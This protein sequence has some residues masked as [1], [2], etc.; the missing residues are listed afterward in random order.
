MM[1][2]FAFLGGLI[3]NLMPCVFPVLSIKALALA[4]SGGES[5]AVQ[6]SHALAYTAG[7]VLSFLAVAGLL[8]VL[9]AG[10]ASLGWGFQLQSPVFV[11]VLIYVLFALGL[12][13]SGLVE[14]GGRLMGAGQSLAAKP[15]H[16]GAFFT[17]VLAVLVASPCTAPF[18]GAALGFALTQ[19]AW[20]SLTV[21][22]ALGLGL[23][24]PFL[25]I[26]FIPALARKLPR[27]GA[28]MVTFRQAMAFPLYLTVVWLL[29]VLARQTD[30]DAVGLVLVGLTGLAFGLWLKS[31]A[32]KYAPAV[33]IVVAL[34]A[35][36]HPALRAAPPAVAGAGI[37]AAAW[38]PYS[39]DRVQALAAGG[40]TV[41]VNFTAD[42]CLTCKVNERTTLASA[43]VQRA[44]AEHNIALV[45]GDWTRYDPAITAALAEHGRS[46]VPLYLVVR[47]D[48]EA[49][50]LPQILTPGGVIE[51]LK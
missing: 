23:A 44:F 40:Q 10:G 33:V 41:F 6:R 17:G 35:L 48:G 7:V 1:L 24:A 9:R 47:P 18:M 45:K 12:S 46:G 19:S 42:W 39:A 34:G 13:M 11:A 38:Q 37:D 22:A 14:F 43:R 28:W 3:L 25:A 26:G 20:V 16:A 30:A 15:G 49:D 4:Q 36:A 51:A 31:R 2:L 32:V 21:F 27:P 29:W 50:V 5:R 8:L